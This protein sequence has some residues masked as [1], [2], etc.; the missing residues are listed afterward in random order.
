MSRTT[1]MKKSQL[2]A[3]AAALGAGG[4]LAAPAA[5]AA[6]CTVTGDHINL[7]HDFPRHS[8]YVQ[9][10]GS[11]LGPEAVVSTNGIDPVYGKVSGSIAGTA[12]DFI[13]DWNDNQGQAHYRGTVGPDGFASGT[14]SGNV[15]PI[16]LW[17]PTNW[18]SDQPLNCDGVNTGPAQGAAK[19]ATVNQPTSIFNKPDGNGTEYLNANGVPIFKQPGQ[20]QLVAPDLCRDNWCHVVAPEV[21]PG[22]GWIYIGN[23][24]GSFP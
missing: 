20:V 15:I 1:S 19:T 4:L 21:P 9:A 2:I 18:K 14:S 23:G 11:T 7:T 10:N 13:I 12:V 5:H 22:D 8:V 17:N 16:N 6:S 24:L 3:A